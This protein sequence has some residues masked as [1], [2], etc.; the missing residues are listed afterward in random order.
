[1]RGLGLMQRV[2]LFLLGVSLAAAWAQTAPHGVTRAEAYRNAQSLA[3]LGRQMFFDPAL[4]ESGRISCSSC[5]DPAFAYG[6][7]NGLA[8][9][10]GGADMQQQGY[11]AAPSLR[12]L[13]IVP[14][15]TEHYFDSEATGDDSID[16]GPTGGLTW[17]GRANRMRDQAAIPL[18]SPYEMANRSAASVVEKVERASYAA[19]LTR[20]ARSQDKAALFA[21]ILEALEAWQQDYREFYPYSSKYDRWLAGK[22]QL[23]PAEQNGLRLFSAPD[24]GNCARCHI[25]ERGANGTPPQFTDYSLV[26]LGA[27]RN[28]E[29]PANADAGWY[30]LGLCGPERTDLRGRDEYCGKFMTPSLRNVA[31]R[32]AFFHN[33]VFHSLKEAVEFYAGR[34]TNPEKWYPRRADGTVAKFDDLP[35]RYQVNMEREAPFG[36]SIG[37]KPSLSEL[38]IADVVAFLETLTDADIAGAAVTQR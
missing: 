26:A 11:R 8:V 10:R 1:V 18:L 38:E 36:R 28:R 16:A 23:T 17:D 5:H 37:E 32:K 19:Q 30:D 14:Q 33:G 4:S 27:P 7:P 9:Q 34:D 21:T 6:P 2:P 29:I 13:Q 15:F 25:A 12:Y 22:A 20:L 3:E 31:I 24:K 35:P